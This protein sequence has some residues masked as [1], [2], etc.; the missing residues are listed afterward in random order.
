[1]SDEYLSPFQLLASFV[2]SI[3]FDVDTPSDGNGSVS[4]SLGHYFDDGE[5]RDGGIWAIKGGISVECEWQNKAGESMCRGVCDMKG[6][7]SVLE[8]AFEGDMPENDLRRLLQANLI[9]LLYGEVRGLF[10]VLSSGSRMGKRL[11]PA[12]NPYEYLEEE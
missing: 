9:S 10:G 4:L 11:L 2:E 1:M 7:V 6:A 12:I 5:L 3:S 8:S